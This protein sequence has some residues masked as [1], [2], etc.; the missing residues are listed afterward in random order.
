MERRIFISS[1]TRNYMETKQNE[2]KESQS[3]MLEKESGKLIRCRVSLCLWN[4]CSHFEENEDSLFLYLPCHPHQ[5]LK[6]TNFQVWSSDFMLWSAASTTS[7][8]SLF[9]PFTD[10]LF[11]RHLTY[12]VMCV[13]GEVDDSLF[14]CLILLMKADITSYGMERMNGGRI[15]LLFDRRRSHMCTQ[16]DTC[17][18]IENQ[19]S[20]SALIPCKAAHTTPSPVMLP[21]DGAHSLCQR[22]KKRVT[23]IW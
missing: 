20:W 2:V 7:V 11:V 9:F 21:D 18:P 1:L 5:H 17:V 13:N 19:D 10:S 3:E 16:T 14:C 22:C 4:S 15:P 23:V 6:E 12:G 8:C